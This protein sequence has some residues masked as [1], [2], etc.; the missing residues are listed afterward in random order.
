[1]AVAPRG[2]GSEERPGASVRLSPDRQL[3]QAADAIL[4]RMLLNLCVAYQGTGDE[5]PLALAD[6][7]RY[8]DGG[9]ADLSPEALRMLDDLRLRLG[10]E[11][12]GA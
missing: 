5:A 3:P 8:V 1:M 4:Q 7:E 12:G 11:R 10:R 6:L 2:R 9:G